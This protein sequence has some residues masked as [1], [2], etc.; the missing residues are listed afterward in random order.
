M[1][2]KL[3]VTA[4][5]D[6]G[7]SFPVKPGETLQVGRSLATAT[8]LTDPTVSRVH[9]EIEVGPDQ[10]VL[11][12]ISE[13]GTLVNGAK[14]TEHTLKP[15]DIIR[16]GATELRYLIGDPGEAFPNLEQLVGQQLAD[17]IIGEPIAR[18]ATGMV[19]KAADLNNNGRTIALKV[20]EAE[21][22]KNEEDVNRFVRAM[23]T[24]I[25]VRHPHL[26]PIQ[27]AGK[28]GPYCWIAMELFEGESLT[29][30]LKQ[31][32]S[33]TVFDWKDA[34]RV[35]VHIGKALDYAHGISVVHRNVTP[36]N[37]L[38]R[39]KDKV[40][41]LGD[42]MLAKAIERRGGDGRQITR[43]G[44]LVGEVAYMAPERT[45]GTPTAD[46]RSDLYSL[47][48]TIYAVLTGRPPFT[49]DNLGKLINKIRAGQLESPQKAQPALPDWFAG[50]VMRLLAKNP[51]E[52]YQSAKS[53]V[54]ELE[55]LGRKEGLSASTW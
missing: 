14:V 38:F 49:D 19:F 25:N 5:P 31:A 36:A 53:F 28:T 26:I 7:R 29:D 54:V 27:G 45:Y 39:R 48:A 50:A 43:T 12:N 44:Q 51:D 3:T 18:G 16:I 46:P 2:A 24:M 22:G 8:R 42:L 40:A 41:K 1:T 21:F 34:F 32:G 30:I 4:G 9:C 20:L 35:A 17:Y 33:G 23:Q 55:Q 47:G 13:N 52:R 37:I 10:A 11:H 15:G 6:T